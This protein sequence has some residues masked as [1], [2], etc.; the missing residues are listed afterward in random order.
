MVQILV[1]VIVDYDE[2]ASCARIRLRG[3][4]QKGELVRVVGGRTNKEMKL[5]VA[6]RWRGEVDAY[7]TGV[8]AGDMVLRLMDVP[9]SLAA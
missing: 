2:A 8:E 5:D 4:I 3:P 7:M 9:R 1:G 6:K